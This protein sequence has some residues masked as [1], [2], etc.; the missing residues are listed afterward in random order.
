[1]TKAI[2]TD[3]EFQALRAFCAALGSNPKRTRA[4]GGNTSL[5]RDGAL[6]RSRA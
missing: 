1:M 2:E 3:P 4:A 5:K 6:S